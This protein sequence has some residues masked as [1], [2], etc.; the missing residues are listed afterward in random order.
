MEVDSH[1][2]KHRLVRDRKTWLKEHQLTKSQQILGGPGRTALSVV[3]TLTH[4]ESQMS[5]T[6]CFERSALPPPKQESL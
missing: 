1:T 3:A 2:T 6:V 4:K 5:E